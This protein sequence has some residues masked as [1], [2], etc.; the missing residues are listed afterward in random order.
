MKKTT[1]RVFINLDVIN[2]K[3]TSEATRL[4]IEDDKG[5][6]L[7]GSFGISA[8][9]NLRSF[10]GAVGIP[11]RIYVRATDREI[12]LDRR[13]NEYPTTGVVWYEAEEASYKTIKAVRSLF[14]WRGNRPKTRGERSTPII[15]CRYYDWTQTQEQ[16]AAIMAYDRKILA[17]QD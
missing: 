17:E 16:I 3:T 2:G 6:R 12:T 11:D 5:I 14:D 8:I 7:Q 15:S 4:E 10:D 13:W 1:L 9:V